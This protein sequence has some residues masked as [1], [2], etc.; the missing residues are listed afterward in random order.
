M[1]ISRGN[2]KLGKIPNIS[3]P[4]IKACGNCKACAPDCYALKSYKQ[5]KNVRQSWDENYKLALSEPGQYFAMIRDYLDV[6]KRKKLTMFRW[7][8]SGD[9]LDG[10]YFLNMIDI[11]RD[12][13]GVKFLCFTKMYSIINRALDGESLPDNLE[14]IF[15]AWSGLDMD[16]PHDI[17][18]AYVQDGNETR[19]P[20]NALE[21]PGNCDTCGLCWSL[22]SIP[23]TNSVC[24][25]IH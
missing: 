1:A 7:H 17:P 9:I 20:D 4:P 8:T 10:V 12:Y 13:P 6:P 14:I 18:V 11:A 23:N 3:L 24:F 19:V 5:Y 2:S 15:S 25:D 16:N 21:C 22:S